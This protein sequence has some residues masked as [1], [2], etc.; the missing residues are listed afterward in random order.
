[1]RKNNQHLQE[2]LTER[3][4]SAFTSLSMCA[5]TVIAQIVTTLLLDRKSVV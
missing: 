3:N 2:E 1:M 4:I 5:L